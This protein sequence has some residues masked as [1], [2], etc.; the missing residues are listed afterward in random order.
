MGG[1]ILDYPAKKI[2]MQG[3]EQG[4]IMEIIETG[5]EFGWS[6]D[7]ILARIQQRTGLTEED[8]NLYIKNY[9]K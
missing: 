1:Q 9:N 7:Q 6:E 5:M 4:R 3:L 2:L 8:A